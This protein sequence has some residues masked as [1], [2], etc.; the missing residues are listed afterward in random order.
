MHTLSTV[1]HSPGIHFPTLLQTTMYSI[2]HNAFIENSNETGN[3]CGFATL[4]APF[5]KE[6]SKQT[7]CHSPFITQ[8]KKVFIG[9]KYLVRKIT[10]KI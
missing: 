5:T 10:V 6:E 9:N 4:F 7:L 2:K 1:M 8:Q 3:D